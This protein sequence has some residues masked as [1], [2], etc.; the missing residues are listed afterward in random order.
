MP[1]VLATFER[2]RQLLFVAGLT[3][4]FYSIWWREM[5]RDGALSCGVGTDGNTTAITYQRVPLDTV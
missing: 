3:M 1:G 4:I 5:A 2:W